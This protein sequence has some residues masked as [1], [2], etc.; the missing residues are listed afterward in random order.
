MDRSENAFAA[1]AAAHDP[2]SASEPSAFPCIAFDIES[3]AIV[4]RRFSNLWT[5]SEM[6][7]LSRVLP[8]IGFAIQLPTRQRRSY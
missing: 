4:N 1:G 3:S 6:V 8:A 5:C 2:E 7:N